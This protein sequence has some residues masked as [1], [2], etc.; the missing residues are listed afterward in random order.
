LRALVYC[1]CKGRR[2]SSSACLNRAKGRK[3]K[4][5][6]TGRPADLPLMAG[7]PF[8]CKESK[9]KKGNGRALEWAIYC[10]NWHPR[11][12]GKRGGRRSGVAAAPGRRGGGVRK[13]KRKG[14]GRG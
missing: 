1:G 8:G 13:K 3:V 4:R 2:R 10:L 9:G 14:E 11:L 12:E 6:G 7:G 5:K